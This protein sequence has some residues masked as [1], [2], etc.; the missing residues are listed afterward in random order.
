MG[1]TD[2]AGS[3]RHRKQTFVPARGGLPLD[4]HSFKILLL[5]IAGFSGRLSAM[6]HVSPQALLRKTLRGI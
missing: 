2:R 4:I 3:R 5:S 6:P 1:V